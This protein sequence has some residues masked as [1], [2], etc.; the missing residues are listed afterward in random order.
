MSSLKLYHSTLDA[1][2]AQLDVVKEYRSASFEFVID[3]LNLRGVYEY[4]Q[5]PEFATNLGYH[6]TGHCI[7]MAMRAYEIYQLENMHSYL[8]RKFDEYELPTLIL[9]ALFHDFGHTGT[10]PDINNIEIAVAGLRAYDGAM[11]LPK[12]CIDMAERLIRV[13]EFPFIHEPQTELEK[14]IR[15]A[16]MM[17]SFEP[18]H[19]ATILYNLRK[20]LKS[21]QGDVSV[22]EAAAMQEKFV[23]HIEI[24]TNAGRAIWERTKPFMLDSMWRHAEIAPE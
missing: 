13:T 6:N 16:D 22:K 5:R 20:E 3:Q 1:H 14:I 9:A 15:D 17:E 7:R 24:L 23:S 18:F 2:R 4:V 12:R 10:R 11:P 21:V 19:I 8:D